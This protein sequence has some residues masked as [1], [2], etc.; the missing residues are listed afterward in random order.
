MSDPIWRS[1]EM[2][3]CNRVLDQPVEA[4]A[5]SREREVCGTAF[6]AAEVG[7][8]ANRLANA[9]ADVGV[10]PGDGVATLI[11]NSPEARLAWWGAARGGGVAVPI[12]TAYKGDYLDH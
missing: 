8:T 3:T 12:N 9:Y 5:D 10:A 2:S 1:G 11:E 7:A 4:D 6:T